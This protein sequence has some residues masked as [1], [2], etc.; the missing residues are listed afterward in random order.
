FTEG[1]LAINGD[2][3]DVALGERYYKDSKE[4]EEKYIDEIIEVGRRNVDW[5][6]KHDGMARRDAHT[7]DSGCARA[8]FRVNADLDPRLQYGVFLPGRE[9]PAWIRFSNGNT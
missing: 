5:G 7:Y 6:L 3:I 4:L 8:F 2:T 1:S 9:Y